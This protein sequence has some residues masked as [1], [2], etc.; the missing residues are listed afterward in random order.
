MDTREK[1]AILLHSYWMEDTDQN[2]VIID[3]EDGERADSILALLKE[4]G[5]ESPSD[6]K[7]II[8]KS[9][10]IIG[11]EES[12]RSIAC[13]EVALDWLQRRVMER[14]DW[15]SPEE[16]KEERHMGYEEGYSDCWKENG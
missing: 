2:S 16:V 13:I 7:S 14:Q 12:L 10:E 4:E 6:L 9:A 15:K 5:W 8:N 11:T 3:V 1:L